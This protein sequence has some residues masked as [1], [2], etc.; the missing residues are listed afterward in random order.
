MVNVT[1]VSYIIFACMQNMA[2]YKDAALDVCNG[3]KTACMT[4]YE[5]LTVQL[6]SES[7]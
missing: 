2:P 5:R 6:L 3:I 7:Q 1:L 4:K